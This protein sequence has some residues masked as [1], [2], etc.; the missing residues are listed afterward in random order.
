ML[1]AKPCHKGVTIIEEGFIQFWM[2]PT[3]WIALDIVV[4]KTVFACQVASEGAFARGGYA[5]QQYDGL[6]RNQGTP[7]FQ[8]SRT[9]IT[10]L[11]SNRPLPAKSSCLL[12]RIEKLFD[13]P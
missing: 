4:R 1:L 10:V 12:R 9:R 3:V 13:L 2:G 6:L 8:S 11:Q 7:F 5:R